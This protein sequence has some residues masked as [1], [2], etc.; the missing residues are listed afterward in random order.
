MA[1]INCLLRQE[2]QLNYSA[3]RPEAY[4]S[5]RLMSVSRSLNPH[6]YCKTKKNTETLSCSRK[7]NYVVF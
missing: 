7:K 1:P 2:N 6:L 5:E 3:S 4:G